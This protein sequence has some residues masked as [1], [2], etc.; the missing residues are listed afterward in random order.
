ML[1]YA[2]KACLCCAQLMGCVRLFATPRSVVHQ[3]PLCLSNFP[4]K[5]TVVGYHSLLQGILPTQGGTR[6][7]CVSCTG[8][9]ILCYYCH[10]GNTISVLLLLLLLSRFSRVQLCATP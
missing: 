7:S 3:A 6:V 8:R 1:S 5:N 4:G 9:R 2:G 10:L